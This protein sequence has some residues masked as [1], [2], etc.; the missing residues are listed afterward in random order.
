MTRADSHA[1][2]VIEDPERF[3]RG[4]HVHEGLALAHE[5]DARDA[6]TEIARDMNDLV[7]NLS[8]S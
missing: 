6:L 5:H 8:G 7:D 1:V 2:G 4:I 3:D